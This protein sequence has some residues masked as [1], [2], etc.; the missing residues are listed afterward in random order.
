[1]FQYEVGFEDSMSA[2][3]CFFFMVYRGRS[4]R[5]N[6]AR[7]GSHESLDSVQTEILDEVSV[8]SVQTT[9]R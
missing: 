7:R 3:V 1:M 4:A 9:R 2:F 8:A 6:A 5:E